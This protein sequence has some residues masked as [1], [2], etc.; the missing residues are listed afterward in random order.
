MKPCQLTGNLTRSAPDD[1]DI[2]SDEG[3]RQDAGAQPLDSPDGLPGTSATSEYR[4]ST[5]LAKTSSRLRNE[6]SDYVAMLKNLTDISQSAHELE[7]QRPAIKERAIENNCRYQE[8]QIR[9]IEMQ[10]LKLKAEMETDKM[11]LEIVKIKAVVEVHP[12][13]IVTFV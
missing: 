3:D 12:N 13:I 10:T 1:N 9:F 4:G 5:T 8:A 2:T 6:E 11:N 7:R